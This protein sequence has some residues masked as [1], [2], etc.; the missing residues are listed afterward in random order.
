MSSATDLRPFI[1][2]CVHTYGAGDTLGTSVIS[3]PL[4]YL[5]WGVLTACVVNEQKGKEPEEDIPPI[6]A[7]LSLTGSY[8]VDTDKLLSKRCI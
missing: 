6:L 7:V 3:R 5:M 1:V 2:T 4:A 8:I